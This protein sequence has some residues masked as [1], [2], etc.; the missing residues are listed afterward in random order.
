M[1]VAWLTLC[2]SFDPIESQLAG[3]TSFPKRSAQT[4]QFLCLSREIRIIS[5]KMYGLGGLYGLSGRRGRRRGE[6][7][8]DCGWKPGRRHP[9]P[10]WAPA[11][12][13]RTRFRSGL[14]QQDSFDPRRVNTSGDEVGVSEDT[15]LKWN[16]GLDALDQQ[17]VERSPHCRDCLEPRGRVHDQLAQ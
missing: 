3:M 15:A 8:V 9:G 14:G 10:A 4:A 12:I 16:G 6:L 13:I 7:P 5:A 2:G 11:S 1:I 17:F